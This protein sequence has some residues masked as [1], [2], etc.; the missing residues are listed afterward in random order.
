[1]TWLDNP[2][3]L[4][5][6][7]RLIAMNLCAVVMNLTIVFLT[8]RWMSLAN[9]AAAAF[10]GG[11]AWRLYK[12]MPEIKREQEQRILTILKGH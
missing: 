12:R 11:M 6:Q 2:D 9:V 4:A 1:M 10:S 7:R 8:M 3:R 5:V